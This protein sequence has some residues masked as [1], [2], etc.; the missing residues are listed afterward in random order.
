VFHQIQAYLSKPALYAPSTKRFWDDVHISKALLEAHLN[1]NWDAASRKFDFI[2]R[3]VKWIASI[4]PPESYPALLDLGCGPGLYAER[5][6]QA[7][8]RVTGLDFSMR[9][10]EYA[11]AQAI[12]SKR[13][14]AYFYQDYL[15]MDYEACFDLITLIYCDFGVLSTQ[16]RSTLLSKIYHALKPNGRFVVDVFTPVQHQGKEESKTWQSCEGGGFWDQDSH[17]CLQAFYRYDQD[18]TVLNQTVVIKEDSVECYHIWEHCFTK[19]G[20]LAEAE[21][22]GFRCTGL[23][24]DVAGKQYTEDGSVICAVFTKD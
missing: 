22:A 13:E 9:S 5:F 16:D 12:A 24:G 18:G 23:Y 4:M 11:Q 21:A 2:D 17:V 19:A 7:G 8:Y 6:D 1:P 20:L 15:T 3:S 10:I 14:I